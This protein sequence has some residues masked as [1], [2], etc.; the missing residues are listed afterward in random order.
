MAYCGY[1][2][3]ALV[4]QYLLN[5][6]IDTVVLWL[7]VDWR[8]T[9]EFSFTRLKRLFDYGGKILV[10]SLTCT[11]YEDLRSLIIGKKYSGEDLAFYTKGKQWPNLIVVNINSS[12]SSVLFP[13]LSE[14][15]DTKDR[16]KNLTRKTISMSSY[17]IAPMLTGLAVLSEDI[18]ALVLTDKWLPMVPYMQICCFYLMFM[19]MQTANLE[20]IKAIGR[21]DLILKMDIVKKCVQITILLLTMNFGVMSIALGAVVSTLF[22][23]VVNA[24]PNKKLLNYSY[25]EQIADLLPNLFW[26]GIMGIIVFTVTN[27][28]KGYIGE[29]AVVILGIAIGVCSYIFLSLVTCN[30]NYMQLF[31]LLKQM[32]ISVF[33]QPQMSEP[34]R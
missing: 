24:W 14:L 26:A 12:I 3:W 8:P 30:Q 17:V 4:A 5:S 25:K 33:S 16:V 9:K 6:F 34:G 11:L 22:S 29:G 15:Q 19:P 13:V 27:L 1:G 32:C 23:C 2:I 18:V 21:S 20:A 31:N 7:L 28:V 10:W